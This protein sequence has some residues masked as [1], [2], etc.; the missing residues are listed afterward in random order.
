VELG[1]AVLAGLDVERAVAAAAAFGEPE[2]QQRVAA[3]PCPYGDG[4]TGEPAGSV[5]GAVIVDLDDT[6]YPQADYLRGAWGAVAEAGAGLGLPRSRLLF[7]LRSICAEGSD[8]GGIIDRALAEI[9]A[10]D[11]PVA[12]LVAAFRAHRPHRLRPYPGARRALASLRSRFPLACVTDGHP[13]GQRAKLVALGL[14]DAFDAVVVSDELGRLWRKPEPRPFL[15][16]ANAL[17]V[18][19]PDVVVIGDRPDKDVV[20]AHRAGMR[21]V[22]VRT[23][24]YSGAP[25][26][27]RPWA[28]AADLVE[29]ARIVL[30]ASAEARVG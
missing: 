15:H 14:A 30:G 3:V 20:G 1:T 5:I 25:D 26:G 29:A 12:P 19:P 10:A 27:E 2:A 8:R 13:E 16:A 18:R 4:R 22:R 28:A 6:V 7:A 11:A 17:G 23:G 9:G 21:A 24:E